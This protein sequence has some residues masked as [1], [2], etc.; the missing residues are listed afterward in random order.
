MT[1]PAT[2]AGRQAQAARV[3]CRGRRDKLPADRR[4]VN[5][6]HAGIRAVGEQA[7]ATLEFWRLLRKLRSIDCV[8]DLVQAI[9]PVAPVMS[10][11]GRIGLIRDVFPG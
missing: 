8:T 6:S 3:P 11:W 9:L 2:G 10:D 4:T 7:M 1:A 5:V